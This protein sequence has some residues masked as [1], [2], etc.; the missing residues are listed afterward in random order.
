MRVKS[1]IIVISVLSVILLEGAVLA[2]DQ[3]LLLK[4]LE[5]KRES[6]LNRRG[7]LSIDITPVYSQDKSIV[8]WT[9]TKNYNYNLNTNIR[10]GLSD[11]LELSVL[12]PY[13]TM[14]KEVFTNAWNTY[15]GAGMGDPRF[16]FQYEMLSEKVNR[17]ATYLTGGLRLPMGKSYF[18]GVPVNELAPGSGYYATTWGL[19]FL[20]SIDPT[21]LFW[22]FDYQWTFPRA[23]YNPADILGYNLGLAWSLN[24][25]VN[26]SLGLSGAVVGEDRQVVN[27]VEQTLNP[28][29]NISGLSVSSNVLVSS[30]VFVNPSIFFGLTDEESDFIFSLGMS[31]KR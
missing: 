4:L 31:L 16:T 24:Q 15:R 2:I 25:S 13:T 11:R 18:D 8:P 21:A 7:E 29:Y 14:Q 17:P 22:G 23:D 27:G 20:K 30:G 3:T 1:V 10:L 28:A 6:Y 5:L 19:S 26:L 9:I 12:V